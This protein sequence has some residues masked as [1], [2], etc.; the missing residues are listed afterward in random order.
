[1]SKK[2]YRL[3]KKVIV[4]AKVM[5]KFLNLELKARKLQKHN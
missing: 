3:G 4:P 1:M 5:E 2:I